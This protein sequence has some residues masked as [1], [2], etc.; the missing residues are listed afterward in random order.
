[1]ASGD[2][3]CTHEE[4]TIR[5]PAVPGTSVYQKARTVP[6]KLT[7]AFTCKIEQM[8]RNNFIEEGNPGSKHNIPVHP[9]IKTKNKD[10]TVEEIRLTMD[11]AKFNK[12]MVL[13]NIDSIP[14]RQQSLERLKNAKIVS[15]FDLSSVF[16]QVK[17][18]PE[19]KDKTTFRALGKVFRYVT[20]PQGVPNVPL[21]TLANK[22]ATTLYAS[23]I[24]H[25][26]VN[27]HERVKTNRHPWGR[28]RL[29]VTAIQ[30]RRCK[31]M[32]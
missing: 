12:T 15:C 25:T 4:A 30:M 27:E 28:M 3:S 20:A 8:L 29:R 24:P 11:F 5:L 31:M 6:S 1:V 23:R 2:Q 22:N 10:G 9:R 17:L 32:M 13:N 21:H 26:K 18:A 7:A 14:T 19:D 16:S